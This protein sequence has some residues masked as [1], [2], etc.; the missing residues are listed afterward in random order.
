MEKHSE[1]ERPISDA[2]LN[3]EKRHDIASNVEKNVSNDPDYANYKENV[4][5]KNVKKIL[6]SGSNIRSNIATNVVGY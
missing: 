4:E 6:V 2:S 1:P 5:I 3:S